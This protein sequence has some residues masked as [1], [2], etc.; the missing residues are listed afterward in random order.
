MAGKGRLLQPLPREKEDNRRA[1]DKEEE[2]SR[3]L[4]SQFICGNLCRPACLAR[5]NIVK[6]RN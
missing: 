3:I 6:W 2:I 4:S 5:G 1:R